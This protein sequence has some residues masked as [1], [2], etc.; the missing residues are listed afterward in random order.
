[1]RL[2]LTLVL[3]LLGLVALWT[4]QAGYLADQLRLNMDVL[5]ELEDDYTPHELTG[6]ENHLLMADYLRPGARPTLLPKEQALDDLGEEL[7]ADLEALEMN[8]P[9][10]DLLRFNVVPAYLD[11]DSLVAIAASIQTLPGVAGVYYQREFV[12]RVVLN[13]RRLA[14]AL[15]ILSGIFLILL[16]YLIHNNVRLALYADRLRIKTQELVGASWGFI[17]RPY[18]WRAARQGLLSGLL[19]AAALAGLC[20]AADHHLP[21]LGLAEHWLPTAVVLA[22]VLLAGVFIN[23]VSHWFVVRRYLRMRTTDLI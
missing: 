19:A 20:Y 17:T 16:F 3:L 6:L 1:M 13:A 8:N 10:R 18:L 5:V 23:F 21:E 4:V 15:L 7:R 14:Y 11:A 12:D 22:G 2:S 9:L